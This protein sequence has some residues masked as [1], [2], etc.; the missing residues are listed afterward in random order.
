MGR[1][2]TAAAAALALLLAACG[3]TSATPLT[4]S[5]IAHKIPGCRHFVAQ[6]PSVLVISDVTCDAP[7]DGPLG[8]VEIATFT[9]SG[10]EQKWI[11]RKGSDGCCVQGHLWAAAEFGP[12]EF[13]R[14]IHALGGREV[15]G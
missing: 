1:R 8:S 15:A 9:S 14:V 3:G 6:A 4:A 5:Q 12:D 11:L 2:I 7:G 13:P 10:N